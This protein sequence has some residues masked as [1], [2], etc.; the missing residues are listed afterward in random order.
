MIDWKKNKKLK[1]DFYK[2][3]LKMAKK[4]GKNFTRKKK[5]ENKRHN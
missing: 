2:Q 1:L 5:R 4:K 3:L